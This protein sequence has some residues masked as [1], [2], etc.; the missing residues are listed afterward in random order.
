MPPDVR[1]ELDAPY[2]FRSDLTLYTRWGDWFAW[3]S[4]ADGGAVPGVAPV[5]ARP[6]PAANASRSGVGKVHR[7]HRIGEGMTHD[8]RRSGTH[9]RRNCEQRI[10]LVRSYL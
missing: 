9:F 8:C 4:I 5:R 6:A 3:L 7:W 10:D 1:G 2:A